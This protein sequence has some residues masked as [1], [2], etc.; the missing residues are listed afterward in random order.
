MRQIYL[1]IAIVFAIIASCQ[2]FELEESGQKPGSEIVVSDVINAS[3]IMSGT[4][5]DAPMTKALIGQQTSTALYGNF[6]KV[7]Q[8]EDNQNIYHSSLYDIRDIPMPSYKDATIVDAQFISPANNIPE[9]YLRT[10]VFNPRLTYN[11]YAS[12]E[13]GVKDTVAYVSRM[14]GWYPATYDVPDGLG[15]ENAQALFRNSGCFK[16]VGDEICVE[17]KNKL[18]GQTDLMMTDMREGRIFT[19]GFM[20]NDKDGCDRNIQPY[21]AFYSSFYDGVDLKYC[22]YFSFHHYLTAVRLFV[23]AEDNSSLVLSSWGE[24]SNVVF[25]NQPTTA[26]ISLPTEQSTTNEESVKIPGGIKSL[27]FEGVEPIFGEV[28]SWSDNSDFPIARDRMYEN[29]APTTELETMTSQLPVT[30]RNKNSLEKTYMGYGL[31]R[32][33]VDKNGDGK[34]DLDPDYVP[35]IQ[36]VTTAGIITAQLPVKWTVDGDIVSLLQEGHIYD[37]IVDI[38]TD[39]TLDVIVTSEGDQKYNNLSPYNV[40]KAEYETAN[41]YVI[42]KSDL[43]D[44]EGKEYDGFI[45]YPEL[46]EDV[47]GDWDYDQSDIA[48]V[49]IYWQD[50]TIPIAHADYVQD[51]V[52][53]TLNESTTK[54]D[55]V[56]GNAVI[57]AYDIKKTVI[58]SWHIW[59][60]DE[61]NDIPMT[62]GEGTVS[63]MDRNLGAMTV[64]GDSP[65]AN[66]SSYGLYYQWGRKDPSPGP[67]SYDYASFDMAINPISTL[68]GTQTS[69]VDKIVDKTTVTDVTRYPLALFYPGS[70]SES[71]NYNWLYDTVDDLWGYNQSNGSGVKSDYDPC[72]Y[73]YR[74]PYHEL[75]AVTFEGTETFNNGRA[76]LTTDGFS[77]YFPYSGWKGDDVGSPQQTHFWYKVN[78][79]ADMLTGVCDNAGNKGKHRERL[80]FLK[81]G[82]SVISTGYS[83]TANTLYTPFS[84]A[85][86]GY[87]NRNTAASVRCVRENDN[88]ATYFVVNGAT[89]GWGEIYMRDVTIEALAINSP[90]N[91]YQVNLNIHNGSGK[92]T[93]TRNVNPS[94]SGRI[95]LVSGSDLPSSAMTTITGIS[96]EGTNI[97]S[98]N[99]SLM[100]EITEAKEMIDGGT[101]IIYSINSDGKR[102]CLRRNGDSLVLQDTEGNPGNLTKDNIFIFNGTTS[103]SNGN[104]NSAAKGTLQSYSNQYYLRNNADFSARESNA[105]N[106]DF[107]NKYNTQTGHDIDITNA[108]GSYLKIDSYAN[109]TVSIGNRDNT[110]DA[111]WYIYPVNPDLI[112]E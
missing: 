35:T 19:E 81:E 33:F 36:I 25:V 84:E 39:G 109:G 90:S 32:P 72:P 47:Q 112:G 45:F 17:F 99:I 18:D 59:V 1:F 104:Y 23:K 91:N 24:I 46:P 75:E 21:G 87:G 14:V 77:L 54:D 44:S 76:T 78:K 110:N 82:Y 102:Y 57:A 68:S 50:S 48:S 58:W 40:S 37:I 28:K 94:S 61:I 6:I 56:T 98:Q 60:V 52:R 62:M 83:Y 79:G 67:P 15:E 34:D 74:V 96:R 7:S 95:I 65:L 100:K 12:E 3:C 71:Y 80:L 103:D 97:L 38:K 66:L 49:A 26:V 8:P 53:L 31:I 92:S 111:K 29:N 69:V 106:L 27:P 22:N 70:P 11:Y 41:C 10:I 73:G 13:G 55:L 42:N 88:E 86:K 9:L 51:Y 101:Y 43:V 63:F 64:A 107:R 30:L 4:E 89:E 16:E 93:E 2:R 85:N 105:V 108:S 20:N 5:K